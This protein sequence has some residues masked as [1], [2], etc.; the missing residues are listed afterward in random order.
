M[1]VYIVGEANRGAHAHATF[2]V[3]Y[4]GAPEVTAPLWSAESPAAHGHKILFPH[5]GSCVYHAV[6]IHTSARPP[7]R[8][9]GPVRSGPVRPYTSLVGE[10]GECSALPTDKK[11]RRQRH[12]AGGPVD[13]RSMAADGRASGWLV[14]D[15]F[16]SIVKHFCRG[17][18]ITLHRP[19]LYWP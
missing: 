14:A 12:R 7:A 19:S 4:N 11:N 9:P 1:H 15:R 3:E 18:R 10:A 13:G 17:L 5:P 16:R 6:R 2:N 8:P